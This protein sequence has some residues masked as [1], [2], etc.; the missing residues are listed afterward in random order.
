MVW[1]TV[2]V[3]AVLQDEV[4]GAIVMQSASEGL[5][6]VTNRALGRLLF[7]TLALSFGLAA[8]LWYFATRLVAARSAA[9]RRRQPGDGRRSRPRG[10]CRWLTTGM[11][12]VNWREI[13]RSCC[14]PWRTITSTCKPWP[15]SCRM[16]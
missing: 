3:P 11:S 7:T 4:H 12:W 5:L 6:L 15:A 2:A 9:Q 1:N 10:F 14:A 13:T 8:G 16:S